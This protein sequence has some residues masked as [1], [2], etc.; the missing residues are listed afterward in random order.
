MRKSLVLAGVA[1]AAAATIPAVTA[2]RPVSADFAGGCDSNN[3]CTPRTF[4]QSL[5]AYRGVGAPTTGANLYAVET[6]ERAE[7]GGAGCPGQPPH[8]PPWA[9]SAG[10]AGNPIATT[11]AEP[12]STIWNRVGVKVYH[13]AFGHTCWYWGIKANGDTLTNGRYTNV[14]AVLRR[15]A[16]TNRVQCVAL[17][18]AVGRSPWGTGDFERDC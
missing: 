12:G 8:R 18:R 14:L 5:L 17:A 4:A 10:P 7:G 1:L 2:S 13:N 11:Q 3:S 15:P 6:W 16:A 9:N